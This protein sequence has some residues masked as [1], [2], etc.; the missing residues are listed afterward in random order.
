[1]GGL[2]WGKTGVALISEG[3]VVVR[4][5]TGAGRRL[6]SSNGIIG[7]GAEK[8]TRAGPGGPGGPG[9]PIGPAGGWT[10]ATHVL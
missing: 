9:G 7:R 10:Y 3:E 8:G 1:M 4:R 2:G 5:G 6:T